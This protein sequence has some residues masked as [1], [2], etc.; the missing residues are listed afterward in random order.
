MRTHTHTMQHLPGRC[1][2]YSKALYVK[3]RRTGD[4]MGSSLYCIEF[5]G[6]V[7]VKATSTL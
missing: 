5:D 4:D 6:Y 3:E 1:V 7:E 2:S